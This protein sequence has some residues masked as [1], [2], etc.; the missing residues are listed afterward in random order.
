M[1]YSNHHFDFEGVKASY[2]VGGAGFPILMIHGSGPGASTIG[3]WR[4]VLEPLDILTSGFIV[5]LAKIQHIPTRP[6]D[7]S[8]NITFRT[9]QRCHFFA[10]HLSGVDLANLSAS[11][12][13]QKAALH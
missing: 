12:G 5:D 4:L 2:L 6:L 11:P 1:S 8:L 9:K 7:I 3:N 13:V 10:A